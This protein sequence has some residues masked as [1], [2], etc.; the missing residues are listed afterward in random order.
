MR[1]GFTGT[2]EGMTDVQ[3]ARFRSGL[4]RLVEAGA[5]L[6]RHGCCVGADEQAAVAVVAHHPEVTVFGHPSDLPGLTSDDAMRCCDDTAYPE[7][8]LDRNRHIVDGCDVLVACPKGM[9]EEQRSGTWA[10]VRYARVQNKRVVI[11]W[12]NGDATWG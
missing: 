1:V 2:R 5:V 12:P 11:V 4:A 3:L 7:P 10:T 6:F 8:P 9:A